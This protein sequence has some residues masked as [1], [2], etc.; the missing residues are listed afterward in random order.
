VKPLQLGLSLIPVAIIVIG[1]IGWVVTLRGNIDAAIGSIE[2]LQDSQY[3]DTDLIERVQDLALQAEESMTKVMWVMEEY[4][5]AIES[6]RDRELDT[7]MADR[8]ADI[9]T[10]QAVVENEMRQIMS[11]HQGFADVLYELGE[12]GLIERRQYGNYK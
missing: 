4:G 1:L 7:E 11:D 8:V 6:I 12:S 10:R 5:P 9:M 3:D 2:E